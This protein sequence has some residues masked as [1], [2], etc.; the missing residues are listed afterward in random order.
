MVESKF[1]PSPSVLKKF[2]DVRSTLSLE[3]VK[4]GECL[5]GVR[6][7]EGEEVENGVEDVGSESDH[8]VGPGLGV[9]LGGGPLPRIDTRDVVPVFLGEAHE[10]LLRGEERW[11]DDGG[12]NI[13]VAEPGPAE[14][15]EGVEAAESEDDGGSGGAVL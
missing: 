5:I 15:R 13:W 9:V 2:D 10:G 6:D 12:K 4:D 14:D 11:G 8:N 3:A 7:E 1:S